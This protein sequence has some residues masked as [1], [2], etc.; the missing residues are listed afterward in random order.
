[1]V[2]SPLGGDEPSLPQGLRHTRRHVQSELIHVTPGPSLA[3]L[4]RGHHR[5]GRVREMF[6]GMAMRRAV[7]TADVTAGQAETEMYPRR[8]HLQAFFTSE[9]ASGNRLKSGHM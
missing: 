2:Q 9:R 6:C 3:G 5:M 1:M 7:A 8:S 4:E